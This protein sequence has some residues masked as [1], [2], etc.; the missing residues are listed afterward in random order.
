MKGYR[1]KIHKE[2]SG[3]WA[4][5]LDINGVYSQAKTIKELKKNCKEALELMFEE[6][7]LKTEPKDYSEEEE[8]FLIIS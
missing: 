8:G 3:F 4:E 1:F 6:P 5:C 2:G 7:G